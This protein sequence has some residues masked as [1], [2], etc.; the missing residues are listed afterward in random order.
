MAVKSKGG[1]KGISYDAA[2]DL[3][4]A[5]S[6]P[7]FKEWMESSGTDDNYNPYEPILLWTMPNH[8]TAAG[9][10]PNPDYDITSNC[11]ISFDLLEPIWFYKARLFSLPKFSYG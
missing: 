2:N 8:G 11:K 6:S 3:V 9:F 7:W 5:K 4:L 10:C 1:I